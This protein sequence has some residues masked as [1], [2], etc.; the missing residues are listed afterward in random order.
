MRFRSGEPVVV[1]ATIAFGMGIDRPDVRFVVHLDMPDS[2]EAYY[3]QIGRAGRDGDPAHTLLLYGGQDIARARHWLTQSMAPEAQKRV[4]R[5][6]LEAMVT[7]TETVACRTKSLLA[8]F[9]DPGLQALQELSG[10]P[11]I[12]LAQACL[13]QVL[14]AQWP[15]AIV[16]A[17]AP[18]R[19][20]LGET[21]RLAGA[22]GLLRAIE[23]MDTT[24][25]AIVEA[26][27]D[28]QARVRHAILE[29]RRAGAR[30]VILGGAGFVGMADA[31]QTDGVQLLDCLAV[32]TQ[33]AMTAAGAIARA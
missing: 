28:H 21:V 15:F 3:Q 27:L 13:Q 29:A 5:E 16:T 12:G 17:G 4:M 30:A 31:L 10:V 19:D 25:L 24:G 6:R 32:A 11:V 1:V 8:C 18:W 2:P 23:V 20:M 22:E 26:P 14:R 9:G 7:L 33:A